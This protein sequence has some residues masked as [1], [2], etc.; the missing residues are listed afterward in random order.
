[1]SRFFGDKFS[2]LPYTGNSNSCLNQVVSKAILEGDDDYDK[3]IHK[4]A[5]ETHLATLAQDKLLSQP[6]ACVLLLDI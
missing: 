1:M 5:L 2:N 6:Q 4:F 3:V